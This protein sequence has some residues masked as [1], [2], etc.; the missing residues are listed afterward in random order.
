L[1]RSA[2]YCNVYQ[3]ID[4]GCSNRD[5]GTADN[6][7]GGTETVVWSAGRLGNPPPTGGAQFTT[8]GTRAHLFSG[9]VNTTFNAAA[10]AP[11][12]FS[13]AFDFHRHDAA[14]IGSPTNGLISVGTG[15]D[16]SISEFSPFETTGNSQ[17]AVLFQ[18]AAN[19]NAANGNVFIDGVATTNFDYLDPLAEHSVLLTFTP[20]VSGAYGASDAISATIEVDGVLRY[21]ETINGGGDFGDLSFATNLF[22]APYIDNLVVSSLSTT[23]VMKGDVDLSGAVNFSDIP[24]FITVLQSGI[25]QAEADC[26]C[27]GAVDFSDIPAFI[28]ILQGG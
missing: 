16:Q 23:S 10:V 5:W 28:A 6:G 9:A 14:V 18:Q 21:N 1:Q 15:Y 7:A 2:A 27:S 13:V 8:N 17:F 26:D 25:F 22:T 19:G 20:A 24:A 4:G 12:G 3:F 11:D